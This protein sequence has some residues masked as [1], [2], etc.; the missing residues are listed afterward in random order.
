VLH[1]TPL[2]GTEARID[3]LDTLSARAARHR[4][5]C[6]RAPRSPRRHLSRA[7]PP[8][9]RPRGRWSAARWQPGEAQHRPEPAETDRPSRAPPPTRAAAGQPPAGR[10]AWTFLSTARSASARRRRAGPAGRALALA[11]QPAAHAEPNHPAVRVS[12]PGR[13]RRQPDGGGRRAGGPTN[14]DAASGWSGGREAPAPSKRETPLPRVV[15]RA[16]ARSPPPPMP[17]GGLRDHPL[18]GGRC[19]RGRPLRR[20]I[21]LGG[22]RARPAAPRPA[23]APR[24]PP[25]SPPAQRARRRAASPPGPWPRRPPRPRPGR[26]RATASPA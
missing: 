8:S 10:R 2:P 26:G 13:D 5:T 17:S 24:R 14:A 19:G 4:A 3:R 22:R 21:D 12:R 11:Q 15:H 23:A 6:T 25:A 20:V 16:A 1:G 9:R 18:A 7:A